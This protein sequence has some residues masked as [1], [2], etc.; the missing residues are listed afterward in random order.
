MRNLK[1]HD[2]EISQLTINLLGVP[3]A[4]WPAENGGLRNI[5]LNLGPHTTGKMDSAM[6]G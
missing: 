6:Q 5:K 1:C 2:Y 4:F 3:A